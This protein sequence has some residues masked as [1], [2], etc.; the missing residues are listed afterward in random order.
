MN[1]EKEDD[2]KVAVNKV[3]DISNVTVKEKTRRLKPNITICNVVSHEPKEDLVDIMIRHNSYLQ[4]VA[5]VKSKIVFKFKKQAKGGT[6]HYIYTVDPEVRGLIHKNGDRI[7]L[8]WSS[9]Q[10]YDRYLPL[11]CFY[12]QRYGHT[13]NNCFRKKNNEDPVCRYCSGGHRSSTCEVD[14]SDQFKCINCMQQGGD[15][16]ECDTNHMVGAACCMV[17]SKEMDRIW[18]DTD[19][20]F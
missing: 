8:T 20:G 14:E 13:E 9:Y 1:F 7:F 4:N 11:I 18:E 17:H 16:D 19:H 12:C 5:D 2:R 15:D 6:E 10:I 3:R